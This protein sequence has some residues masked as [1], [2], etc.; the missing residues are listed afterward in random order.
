MNIDCIFKRS[1]KCDMK[2]VL[3]KM[4]LDANGNRSLNSKA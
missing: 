1:V 2:S 4:I 3:V